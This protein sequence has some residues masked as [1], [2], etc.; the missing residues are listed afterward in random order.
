M[1]ELP[2][3]EPAA[4]APFTSIMINKARAAAT[5]KGR[6]CSVFVDPRSGLHVGVLADNTLR[7]LPVLDALCQETTLERQRKTENTLSEPERAA[8]KAE[9]YTLR[10]TTFGDM[11][12][13]SDEGL[14]HLYARRRE[15]VR[16]AQCLTTFVVPVHTFHDCV[17]EI[18]ADFQISY[19]LTAEA[20]ESMHVL[21]E[22]YMLQPCTD[23]YDLAL[24]LGRALLKSD[25]LK[26]VRMLRG[27]RR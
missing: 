26:M 23:A 12:G 17:N 27:G 5:A 20:R 9:G 4:K 14:H 1:P 24:R 22:A 10:D 15:E 8:M 7:P 11:A 2:K 18:F 21:A 13:W 25:D 16:H 19:D 6:P 3:L